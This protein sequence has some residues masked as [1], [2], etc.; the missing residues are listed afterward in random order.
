MPGPA[1]A[2]GGPK[3][4]FEPGCPLCFKIWNMNLNLVLLFS[5]SSFLLFLFSTPD[6]FAIVSYAD[7]HA[8]VVLRWLC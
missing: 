2:F 6:T 8:S 4:D 7:G 3:A 5:S 1:L